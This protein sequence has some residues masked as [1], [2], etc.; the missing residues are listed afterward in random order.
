MHCGVQASAPPAGLPVTE[1]QSAP[2]KSVP[3][4]ASAASFTAFPHVTGGVHWATSN[5]QSVL[6]DNV[7]VLPPPTVEAH[8]EPPRFVPSHFS[9]PLIA[10]SPQNEQ[11]EESS[12]HVAVH[13]SVPVAGL[14]ATVVHVAPPKS[15]ASHF[16]LIWF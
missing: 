8:V 1:L 5:E 15:V 11:A 14:P 4:H 10:P 6:H 7:P 3:S 2:P 12:V 13:A 16:S 9:V